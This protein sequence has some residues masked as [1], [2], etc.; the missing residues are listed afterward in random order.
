MKIFSLRLPADV[1]REL[2]HRARA[3]DRT[4]S[5]FVRRLLLNAVTTLP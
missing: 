5:A 4:T 2:E 1:V 3:D